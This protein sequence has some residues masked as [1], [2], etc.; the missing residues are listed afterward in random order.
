MSIVGSDNA[1]TQ[2]E[3]T[4]TAWG[5]FAVRTVRRPG[6]ARATFLLDSL[7]LNVAQ[8]VSVATTRHGHRVVTIRCPH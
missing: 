4:M 2:F 7:L 6:G 5:P 1:T 3:F 8:V